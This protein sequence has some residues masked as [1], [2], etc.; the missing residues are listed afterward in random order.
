MKFD[1][2]VRSVKWLGLVC[3]IN[4]EVAIGLVQ[5]VFFAVMLSPYLKSFEDSDFGSKPN[6]FA[7]PEL[8]CTQVVISFAARSLG[9]KKS[10]HAAFIYSHLDS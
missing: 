5:C 4:I 1:F 8:E 7:I 2:S 9:S 6:K 3:E 10:L